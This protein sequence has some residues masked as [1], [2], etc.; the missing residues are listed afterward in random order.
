MYLACRHRPD[1]IIS[2]Q[3]NFDRRAYPNLYNSTTPI[4]V[5]GSKQMSI[6]VRRQVLHAIISC[7]V[8]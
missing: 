7:E 2:E 8:V 3:L 1:R 4:P 6:D 5:S